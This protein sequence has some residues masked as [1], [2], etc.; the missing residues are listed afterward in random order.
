MGLFCNCVNSDAAFSCLL[1]GILLPSHFSWYQRTAFAV[2]WQRSFTP[3][4]FHRGNA[5][6]RT[7]AA[8]A[9][10]LTSIA[11]GR[12]AVPPGSQVVEP[13]LFGDETKS[14][15]EPFWLGVGLPNQERQRCHRRAARLEAA[16]RRRRRCAHNTLALL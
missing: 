11:G 9:D 14:R 12:L 8:P 10:H 4:T 15:S 1:D 7:G 2:K 3:V 6:R 13:S 16:R 5:R